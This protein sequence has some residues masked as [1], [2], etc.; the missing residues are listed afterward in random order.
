MVEDDQGEQWSIDPEVPTLP[1][2][3]VEIFEKALIQKQWQ[4]AANHRN[5]EGL[6][7][8]ADVYIAKRVHRQLRRDGY[9]NEAGMLQVV[10]RGGLWLNQRKAEQG[11]PCNPV[12]PLCKTEAEDERQ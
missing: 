4:V 2:Q 12:C 6:Q 7:H 11:Y 5:G 1:D 9:K 8:G 3:M 10:A